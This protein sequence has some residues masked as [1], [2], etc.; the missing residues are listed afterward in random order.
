VDTFTY[1]V[2]DGLASSGT[3]TVTITVNSLNDAPSFTK[4]AN[5]YVLKNA[6]AQTILG[7]ATAI[8]VGPTDEAAQSLSFEVSTD[9][10]ALF[11]VLPAIDSTTGTLTYTP[12]VDASGVATITVTLKDDG[13]TV[14]GG[15]DTSAAQT[16]TITVNAPP[17]AN[18]DAYT[19]EQDHTLTI[20]ARRSVLANDTD[21]DS[22]TLTA[23]IVARPQHGTVRLNADGSFTY[24]P[25]AGFHGT[26]TFTYKA[27]DGNVKS[28]A[29]T[30]TITVT[31]P[32]HAPTARNLTKVTKP[33]VSA[34]L[35]VLAKT[36][37]ADSDPLF[38]RAVTA[39]KFGTA[40]IN[41]NGTADNR[42]DDYVVYQP[43]AG[44]YADDYFKYTV[45]DGR[46]GTASAW[47]IIT[48]R[49]AALISSADGKTTELAVV[50]TA[51]RDSIKVW[52]N[53]NGTNVMSNGVVL[54]VFNP[55]GRI[56]VD[57]RAGNDTLDA[58]SMTRSVVL[59]GGE[60]NDNLIGTAYS[61]VF[62][63]G[64]GTDT[65]HSRGGRDT[66]LDKVKAEP[67]FAK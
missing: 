28:S 34:T 22:A 20:G 61:D 11:S 17:V 21:A 32:N 51:G 10:D 14:L 36:Y 18:N 52:Q 16:F 26:D 42:A 65:F 67:V 40:T 2:S 3:A 38:I 43:K 45:S 60:G 7:W 41:N 53:R 31:P 12:A 54:G 48:V 13:G 35:N 57:G 44:S 47:A 30:V 64:G 49:G 15:V 1:H 24:T 29:A 25:A 37:D 6:G 59:Y 56:I 63:G 66:Y 4:G 27:N 33:G 50:G 9:N 8:S 19:V 58:S 5:Q 23:G 62:S 55:T 39:P 46:G